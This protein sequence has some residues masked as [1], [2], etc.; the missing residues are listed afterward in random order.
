M[1][2]TQATQHVPLHTGLV[3]PLGSCSRC[4]GPACVQRVF[5]PVPAPWGIDEIVGPPLCGGADSVHGH[6]VPCSLLEGRKCCRRR[7]VSRGPGAGC[8]LLATSGPWER[9]A[10][11]W[12]C[13]SSGSPGAESGRWVLHQGPAVSVRGSRACPAAAPRGSAETM[14]V[15]E[16]GAAGAARPS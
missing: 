8:G 5:P 7:G 10:S 6:R 13:C 15:W 14:L 11:T 3:R 9:R 16:L 1:L 4:D 2:V 12:S